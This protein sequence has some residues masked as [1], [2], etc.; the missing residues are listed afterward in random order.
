MKLGIYVGSFNPVH[1]GH[2]EVVNYLLEKKYV[3]KVMIIPTG[4]YWDKNDLIDVSH[5]INMLRTY[6]TENIIIDNKLNNFQYTYEVIDELKKHY[7]KIY[8]IIGDD[9]LVNLHLWKN[10]DKILLN[11]IIVMNRNGIDLNQ[12]INNFENKENFI[13]VRD[14]SPVDVS[15][16]KIR[17][18]ITN[19]NTEELNKFLDEKVIKYIK[20]NNLY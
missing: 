19:N 7:E 2:I 10:I 16:T 14:Y 12:Y 20:D 18:L 15:S 3:D 4:N 17:N 1:K 13:M 11:K 5:R 6:E 9:N 8:L